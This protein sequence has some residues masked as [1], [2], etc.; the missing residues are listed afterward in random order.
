MP[1]LEE[2]YQKDE[3]MVSREIAGEVILVPIRSHVADLESIYTLNETAASAWA[4][5]DG[6]HTLSE[7]CDQMVSEFEVNKEEARQDLFELVD[8]LLEI[9]AIVK[10]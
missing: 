4:L 1:S 3:S 9:E 6:K 7:V 2:R 8:Q 5:L 10:V